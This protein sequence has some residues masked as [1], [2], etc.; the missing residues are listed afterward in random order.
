MNP[1]YTNGGIE[2]ASANL[3]AFDKTDLLEAGQ[4]QTLTLSFRAEDMA[5]YDA[6]GAGCY[7]LEA[8]EA[9]EAGEAVLTAQHR[10]R[11][12]TRMDTARA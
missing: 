2:K 1:P 12:E 9:G 7:V 8:G 5:S 3:L 6:D 4:S 11:A 10:A